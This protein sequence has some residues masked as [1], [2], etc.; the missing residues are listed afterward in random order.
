MPPVE[1]ACNPASSWT[2]SWR[3]MPKLMVLELGL[4]VLL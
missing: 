4:V 1:G 2:M 3:G